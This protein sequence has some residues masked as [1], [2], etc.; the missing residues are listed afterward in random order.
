MLLRIAA[1]VCLT[2]VVG[3]VQA[4]DECVACQRPTPVIGGVKK[5]AVATAQA[6]AKVVDAVIPGNCCRP[7]T[8]CSSHRKVFTGRLRRACCRR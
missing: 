7:S 1:F 4:S 8:H 2:M 5:V 6:T 3:T